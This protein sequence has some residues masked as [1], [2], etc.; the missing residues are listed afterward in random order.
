M[1]DGSLMPWPGSF[2]NTELWNNEAILVRRSCSESCGLR[3]VARTSVSSRANRQLRICPSAVSRRRSHEAQNGFET[4]AIIPT[5][6]GPPFTKNSSAGAEPRLATGVRS[7]CVESSPKIS[8]AVTI[9][10]FS[11]VPPA[12]SGICSMNRRLQPFAKLW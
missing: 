2:A 9:D 7:N 6:A 3:R 8:A 10:D 5:V 12:S 11:Q 4:L 1:N